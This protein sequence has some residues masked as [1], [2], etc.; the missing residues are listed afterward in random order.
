MDRRAA[1]RRLKFVFVNYG[2]IILE[3]QTHIDSN[4]ENHIDSSL[5]KIKAIFM[6]A[7]E[8]I[9]NLKSGEKIPATVLASELGQEIGMT[10]PQLY[11]V[12]KFMLHSYPSVDV[13]R[14]AHGG[15]VKR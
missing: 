4:I 10:G 13:K 2:D 8:R 5:A 15:I 6:K 7:S 14:G 3:N 1:Q 12:L 11:P 9:E